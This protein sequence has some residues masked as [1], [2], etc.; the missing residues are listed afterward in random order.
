MSASVITQTP[1]GINSDKKTSLTVRA[2]LGFIA[3][4]VTNGVVKSVLYR[5]GLK[6]GEAVLGVV[7]IVLQ[8]LLKHPVPHPDDVVHEA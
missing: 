3:V 6:Q 2:V 7:V 4:V 5:G 8:P 1:G